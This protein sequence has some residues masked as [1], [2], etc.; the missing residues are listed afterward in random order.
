LIKRILFGSVAG[1]SVLQLIAG[2]L[3]SKLMNTNW[4]LITCFYFTL[5]IAWQWKT[6]VKIYLVYDHFKRRQRVHHYWIGFITAFIAA[7]IFVMA[8]SEESLREP[9]YFIYFP[10]MVGV[11]LWIFLTERRDIKLAMRKEK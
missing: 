10:W 4:W 7:A 1:F 5:A 3:C 9:M 11:T 8:E 2:I 6:K